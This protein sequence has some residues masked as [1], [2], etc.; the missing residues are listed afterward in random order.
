VAD[1]GRTI[2]GV[3]LSPLNVPTGWVPLLGDVE[4]DLT[5]GNAEPLDVPRRGPDRRAPDAGDTTKAASGATEPETAWRERSD[6]AQ[7]HIEI[8]AEGDACGGELEPSPLERGGDHDAQRRD[9][10]HSVTRRNTKES[11]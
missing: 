11:V 6:E 10:R 2:M 9:G 7:Q 4:H 5:I 1:P 8:G 3:A